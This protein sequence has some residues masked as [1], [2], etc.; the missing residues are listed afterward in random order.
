MWS[1]RM[2]EACPDIVF[3][4]TNTDGQTILIPRK[5]LDKIREVN[6]QLT[7]ETTLVIEEVIYDK[8]IIRDVRY[9]RLNLL[10]CWKA[11]A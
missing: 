1:E 7:K 6:E 4:Q 8:M 3:L 9:L 2:I 11:E 5:D 10:N